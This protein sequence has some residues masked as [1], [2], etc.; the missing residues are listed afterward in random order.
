MWHLFGLSA[1]EKQ[2]EEQEHKQGRTHENSSRN[3]PLKLKK[4]VFIYR[5][6]NL[7]SRPVSTN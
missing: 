1:A 3:N 4:V 5:E 6:H 2:D 7:F